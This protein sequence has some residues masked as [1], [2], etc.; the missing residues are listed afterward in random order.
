MSFP[1]V[2]PVGDAALSVELGDA[3]SPATN[4]RVLSL[5]RELAL[6][7]FEGFRRWSIALRGLRRNWSSFWRGATM[8]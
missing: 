4:A 2:L 3:L 8:R 5:D 7:P 1:R 6:A